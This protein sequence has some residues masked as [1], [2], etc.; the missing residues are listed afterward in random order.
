VSA[1]GAKTATLTYDPLGR[2]FQVSS[3][4]GTTQFLYD[5]DSL[6][7]EY[8]GSG[9][10]LRR[11]VDG[12]GADQPLLWYEG[13]AL[14]SRRGLFG[15]HQGSIVVVADANG[16][17]LGINA[18]DAYGVPNANNMGRFQYT[19]QAW[20]A[21]LGL[22]HYKARLYSPTLGRFLQTDPIGYDDDLN[23]YA[24]VRNDPLN[25]TDSSGLA[26]VCVTGTHICPYVSQTHGRTTGTAGSSAASGRTL[27]AASQKAQAAS[28]ASNLASLGAELK[29]TASAVVENL[30]SVGKALGLAGDAATA[31]K[32]V[33]EA[34]DG[35]YRQAKITAAGATID[36]AVAT[37]AGVAVAT[38]TGSP[39]AGER[40]QAVTE[41]VLGK[42][43]FGESAAT[44]Y[45]NGVDAAPH[46]TLTPGG[47]S[48]FR[49]FTCVGRPCA[50][51]D[52]F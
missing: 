43:E 17:A 29:G 26:G 34:E 20:I 19:G 23:L 51:T 4:S 40:T 9:T 32:A 38:Y 30:T 5:G 8:N 2:L 22:Y 18:Y 37:A 50:P 3:A 52:N 6:V 7:A 42:M 28:A 31:A 48:V 27:S 49:Q 24:Y 14:A 47:N 13:A 1:S 44:R 39:A 21:E 12:P 45:F 46:A 41:T 33:G 36:K 16:S 11:Y 10:Q 15:N 35:N 25:K